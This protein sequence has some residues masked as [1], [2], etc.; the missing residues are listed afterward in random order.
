MALHLSEQAPSSSSVAAT[1]V[2]SYHITGRVA[3]D[4]ILPLLLRT[5]ADLD[6]HNVRWMPVI[7]SSEEA[8][9]ESSATDFLWENAPRRECKNVRDWVRCY[10]HLPNGS[11]LLDSKWVLGRL[12]GTASA[13][14][15]AATTTSCESSQREHD[16]PQSHLATLKTHCFRGIS[17]FQEFAERVG[18]L[19]NGATANKVE[20][21]TTTTTTMD[22]TS[23][24]YYFRDLILNDTDDTELCGNANPC[25]NQERPNLWVVKDSHSNGA[26]GIWVVGP[27]NVA[28]FMLD[29]S[30]Q[31]QQP[32][33]QQSPLYEKHTYV[34]QA[35][36]WPPV[37]FR[38]RKCHVRVYAAWTC[39]GRA[40]CHRRCFLHVA[41]DPFVLHNNQFESSLSSSSSYQ[42]SVHITNCCANS[43]D[44]GK[45]AG[46]ICADLEAWEHCPWGGST[47]VAG[48]GGASDN[49]INF[50][51]DD[52]FIVGLAAFAPSIRASIAAL[53]DRTFPFLRGGQGNRGFEYLGLDF[54]LSYNE[55]QQPVA[56][57]LEVN[58]PP[59]QDTATGLP[60]ADDLHDEVIRDLLTLWVYPSV[61]PGIQEDRG[62]WRCVYA[63]T[64][65]PVENRE[66]DIILPSKAAILN[67]IRWTLYERKQ[68]AVTTRPKAER[69]RSAASED[70]EKVCVISARAR[71]FFPY[72]T[73]TIN[74]SKGESSAPAPIYFENAG[75]T[76]VP[77]QV[78]SAVASSLES[79]HRAVAGTQSVAAAKA[80]LSVLLGASSGQYSIF[81]N[82]NASTL[83]SA[84]AQ[85]YVQSGLLRAG[86]E[87]VLCSENHQ[88]NLQP[89]LG[90][91][92]LVGAVIRW[93]D[94]SSSADGAASLREILSAKTRIVAIPHASNI[95]GEIWDLGRLL[96][97]V[98]QER[99]NG[100]AHVVVDGVA[101][102]PHRYAAVDELGVDWYVVS[103]HKLFG[104]HLGAL[105]GRTTVVDQMITAGTSSSSSSCGIG[106]QLGT[107]NYEACEGVQ[108]I[109]RYFMELNCNKNPEKQQKVNLNHD[110]LRTTNV[111]DAFQLIEQA[112]GPLVRLL[113]KG[114][115]SSPKV[116]I[117]G[118][119][120]DSSKR[121]PVVSF[122]H[123]AIPSSQI[124]T[125]CNN[126]GVI[127][128]N[129]TFLCSERL[130][131]K[132]SI[133]VTEGAVR[134]S[135]V[136]YNTVA[137]VKYAISILEAIPHWL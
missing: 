77:S 127:C 128:R 131:R 99:T 64:T 122:V 137:E 17:G 5:A 78:I 54:I 72:F 110:A 39:D 33:Q 32:Q 107:V 98:I 102:A 20:R 41:N 67:K 62:G 38:R 51:A 96:K 40:W 134:F 132:H 43:H 101:A 42:D 75:G 117:L 27:A 73:N 126:G 45:F 88:A 133:D 86:D 34:A 12:L 63:E 129:G 61:L 115:Q 37:L 57:L 91:A 13:A 4:R 85:L 8:V 95:L 87:I 36:T 135:L 80:T 81:L 55:Q 97:P 22:E 104:P 1:T 26:G 30:T 111:N 59:S 120:A 108:A 60:H 49:T 9:A 11:A 119:V 109:G 94:F 130:Q 114:L 52:N 84:L 53:A 79:R 105:F 103:C 2:L 70:D 31:Q 90:A 92:Q 83:L 136:H 106:L 93:W 47:T 35:Y 25:C 56:Y 14:A 100:Y 15:S 124:V 48:G 50:T 58:A 44:E 76:Q 82:A 116:R 6:E 16:D 123:N 65:E 71:S 29:S 121:I 24:S 112:E 118:S 89:W 125:A 66:G 3:H 69:H 113:L 68:L 10:S 28:Q 23:T 46:E 18:L 74:N 7:A 19:A 21:E